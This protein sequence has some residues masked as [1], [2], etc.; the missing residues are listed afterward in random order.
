MLNEFV[1]PISNPQSA[2]R[3]LLNYHIIFPNFS[4]LSTMNVR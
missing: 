3:N 2:I 4:R 1:L